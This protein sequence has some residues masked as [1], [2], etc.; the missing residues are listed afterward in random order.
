MATITLRNLPE[1]IL[2]ALKLR[3]NVNGRTL[4]EEILSVLKGAVYS[5]PLDASKI[6]KTARSVRRM[7]NVYLTEADLEEFKNHGRR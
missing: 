6:L 1:E 4:N 7:M 3:A 2:R 5:V